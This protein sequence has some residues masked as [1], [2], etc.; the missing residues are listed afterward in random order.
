[1]IDWPRFV[2]IVRGK[3]RFV[4]TSHIRPDC[5]ALG[6]ELAMAG[7]LET[8]GKEVAIVNAY[9]VPPTLRFIDAADRFKQL[10]VNFSAEQI[11]QYDALLVLDTSAWAQLGGMAEILKTTRLTKLV[12]DHHQSADD[13]GAE[14]FKSTEAEATGRLVVDA[15]DALGVQLSPEIARNAF[16]ALATDTGWFRFSSTT[17]GTLRLAARLVELGVRP[18]AVYRDLYENDTLGRLRLIGRTLSRAT[19]ER[20]GRLIHSYIEL[21]DFEAAGAHPSESEDIIN[22]MLGVSGTQVAV[23]LVGQRTGGF[24]VSFRSR[25]DVDC[26]RLAESFGGGG[27]KKAAGALLLDDLE[28]AQTKVLDAVRAAMD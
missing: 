20:D 16:L 18:D 15:A 19:T 25:C 11:E 27:H 24:K 22:M 6:S 3:R 7:I 5:D 21:E 9:A 12:L 23:L 2:E 28:T 4:L 10:G 1:M 8:L 13:L 26:S 17:A 14:V